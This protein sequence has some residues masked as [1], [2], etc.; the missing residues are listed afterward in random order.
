MAELQKWLPWAKSDYSVED[1]E[2]W[3]R[4]SFVEFH[5][6]KG[7]ST[8]MFRDDRHIGNVGAFDLKLDVGSC[9]IG[10]WLRTDQTGHGYMTEAVTALSL[11]LIRHLK[12]HRLQIKCDP[13]NTASAGVATRCG[14][15]LDGTLRH[16]S[17]DAAGAYRDTHVFSRLYD[18]T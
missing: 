18:P 1:G 10:Y 12:M 14:Y 6:R 13:R 5:A 3:C 17:R 4:R 15:R 9:E 16:D 7:I 11:Y 2:I 8:I